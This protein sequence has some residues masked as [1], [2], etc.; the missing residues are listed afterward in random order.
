MF[1]MQNLGQSDLKQY[2]TKFQSSEPGTVIKTGICPISLQENDTCIQ[3]ITDCGCGGN[4]QI[5]CPGSRGLCKKC[6]GPVIKHKYIDGKCKNCTNGVCNITDCPDKPII[7]GCPD[8][9]F[10]FTLPNNN[11]SVPINVSVYPFN[12]I[13]AHDCSSLRRNISVELR[14]DTLTWHDAVQQV[15]VIAKDMNGESVCKVSVNVRDVTAPWFISCP[16]DMEFYSKDLFTTATWFDPV[17]DDNVAKP[18]IIQEKDKRYKSHMDLRVGTIY[19][20]KYRAK[21]YEGNR[22]LPCSFTISVQKIDTPCSSPPQI[23]QG[24]LFC[25]GDPDSVECVIKECAKDFII[26]AEFNHTYRCH[27]G[28]WI[29]PFNDRIQTGACLKMEFLSLALQLNVD[30]LIEDTKT[31]TKADII[32]CFQKLSLCPEP[33]TNG[34]YHMCTE[35]NIQLIRKENILNLEVNTTHQL[36]FNETVKGVKSELNKTVTSLSLAFSERNNS[37]YCPQFSGLIQNMSMKEYIFCKPGSILLPSKINCTLCPPGEY[38]A[39]S[40]CRQCPRGYYTNLPGQTECVKCDGDK[41]TYRLISYSKDHCVSM[42]D[43]TPVSSN[44]FLLVGIVCGTLLL[45]SVV[46]AVTVYKVRKAKKSPYPT[47]VFIDETYLGLTGKTGENPYD[48]N[49]S[50]YDEI[51]ADS[52]M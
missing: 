25:K 24:S 5:C 14:K 18:P 47:G 29:P 36:R 12:T 33:T 34:Y 41:T 32:E 21:D 20:F 44:T 10:N 2:I 39:G 45:I 17:A 23:Q 27:N 3:C 6:V 19:S 15:D 22:G 13:Q 9:V 30:L 35:F 42:A 11:D 43:T 37:T 7:E 16:S 4:G 40:T 50:I 31:P 48:N 26:M 8:D 52:V 51:P 28:E 1:Q 49:K 38:E 46:V